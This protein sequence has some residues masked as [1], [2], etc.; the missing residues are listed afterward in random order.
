MLR[1]FA[2]LSLFWLFVMITSSPAAAFNKIDLPGT[3][4]KEYMKDLCKNKGSYLEGQGQYGCMTN[5]GHPGWASDACGINCSEKTNKCYGW[6]PSLN[7][8]TPLADVLHPPSGGAKS[9][10]K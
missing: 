2:R 9:S 1:T 8:Q 10:G 5:C 4:T 7:P 3:R 6:S